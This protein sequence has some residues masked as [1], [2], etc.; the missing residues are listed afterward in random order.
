MAA[1]SI[2]AAAGIAAGGRHLVGVAELR[3][4]VAVALDGHQRTGLA[5]IGWPILASIL[6]RAD[7][8]QTKPPV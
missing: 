7:G 4:Q 8:V 6:V 2:V 3:D 5:E 1:V